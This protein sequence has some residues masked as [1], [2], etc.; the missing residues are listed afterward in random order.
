MTKS[1]KISMQAFQRSSYLAG[2]NAPY[3]EELY[4]QY[5]EDPNT[6]A[7]EWRE[8]FS[9]L[10]N[11]QID[12]DT[13]HAKIQA[14]F[15]EFASQRRA[16]VTAIPV[17]SK[18][19]SV[20]DLINAYRRY[21]HFNAGLDPLDLVKSDNDLRLQLSHYK[22]SKE[23]LTTEF[24][25]R[26]IISQASASLQAI[27]SALQNIYTGA[28][29]FEY[30]YIDNQVER[31]WLQDYIEV[32]LPQVTFSPAQKI[33]YLEGLIAADSL[34]KYFDSK[35]PGQKRFS[36]EGTDSVIPLLNELVQQ[37]GSAGVG[38]IVIGM[39]H[40]GRLNVLINVLGNPVS[41]IV[42]EFQGKKDYGSTS[43]DVKYHR[44]HSSDIETPNGPVH[45]SLAFNP[46][47]LECINPV[48]MG[49]VR[50]RQIRTATDH[51]YNYAFPVMIHGDAAFAGEGV[52]METLQMSQTRAYCVGGSI[53]I[54]LNNQVGFTTSD[55]SDARSARYS[56]ALARMIE[57]PILH[58]NADDAESVIKVLQLALAYR[59]QFHK[60]V[61]IELWGYRRHGHQ[62]VDEP[63]ATQPLMYQVIKGHPLPYQVYA[64]QLINEK[65]LGNDQAETMRQN[66]RQLL[67]DGK[68]TI[69][70]ITAG[71]CHKYAKNWK[72]FLEQ[73]W[74][75]PASTRVAKQKILKLAAKLSEYP[76]NFK[77]QR[78][79]DMIYQA[80]AKMAAGEQEIDWGFGECLAYATLLTEGYPVRLSGQD[81]VRG[82][83]FHRQSAVFDQVSG[84]SYMPL[85]HLSDDQA[86]IQIYNSLLAECG[87]LG[88][89]YGYSTA[90]PNALVIWEAQFGDFANVAQM[91]IDQFISSAWQKW[92]RLAGLTLLLPHGYEGMG[93]EH[94]SA[95]MERYLQLCAQDNM[96]VC[97]PTT[98]A[99]IFHLLR[100][101]VIRPYRKPLIIMSPKSLLRHRLATSSLT[102]LSEGKFKLVI[103][104]VDALDAEKVTRVVACSGKVYYDL[105]IKRRELNLNHIAIVRI[106]QLYPFPYDEFSAELAK[107]PQAKEL[108][109]C[110]E[111]PKNQ[112][113][114]FCSFDRFLRAKSQSMRL[115][116]ATRPASAAPAAGYVKLYKAFQ[117]EV[118]NRALSLE[119]LEPYAI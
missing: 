100:R 107:Y 111:E 103:G 77:L 119:G 45:L 57:A 58:V 33:K 105:L 96:Q 41:D 98:P 115:S 63:R 112:G 48:L 18:Q 94:S 97:V 36:I 104:E 42:A 68:P 15:R 2:A 53:H 38:E 46:S 6:V 79:V 19:Q 71:L 116:F 54:I 47:H 92:N 95:R 50:A 102:E 65:V 78:N 106:E 76:G 32:K 9:S 25:T 80:R 12:G 7:D 84:K 70:T 109:W 27:L 118:I 82:T 73:N 60:D 93:P 11:G 74:R 4:E 113:A 49:S 64:K 108:V 39:A 26:G 20:D 66:Y 72:P 10:S 114:W 69:K 83:F 34:E 16:Q 31:E 24:L 110:Q 87:P 86:K 28:I 90:N 85:A 67:D 40:R 51:S 52:V 29:G 59:M 14:Q 8:F 62:E 23:D 44:G 88:F 13:S 30:D 99:Q 117:A 43:G 3:I 75:A 55:P 61:V 56:S 35:F 5:L 37:A 17:N 1:T 101:Q 21:G 81:C 91:Y 22:L 89:E